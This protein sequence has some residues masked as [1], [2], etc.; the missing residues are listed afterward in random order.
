MFLFILDF[1]TGSRFHD[2]PWF[3]RVLEGYMVFSFSNRYDD[4]DNM[5]YLYS[6]TSRAAAF[7]TCRDSIEFWKDRW[8]LDLYKEMM[9]EIVYFYLYSTSSLA[10][11][12]RTCRDSIEFWIDYSYSDWLGIWI[13]TGHEFLLQ[14]GLG[15]SL[16]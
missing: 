1:I 10:A 9:M 12:F 11:A 2:M 5:F 14:F 7:R 6:T 16:N 4:E 13:L 15:Y 8:I 3:R